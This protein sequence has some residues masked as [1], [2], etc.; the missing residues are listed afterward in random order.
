MGLHGTLKISCLKATE[1]IERRDLRPLH[2]PERLGLWL[3]L[4]VCAAC[5]AYEVQSR[6]IDTLLQHRERTSDIDTQIL[7]QRIIKER[8]ERG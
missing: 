1:L 6:I 7:E 3:H 8:M 2:L 5:R 4:R